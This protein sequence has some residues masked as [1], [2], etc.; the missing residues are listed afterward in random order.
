MPK[1][2]RMCVRCQRITDD[3]VI[4]SEVHTNSGPGWNVYACWR[5]APLVPSGPDPMEIIEAAERRRRARTDR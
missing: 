1:P 5:C 4:V 3:L 2:L